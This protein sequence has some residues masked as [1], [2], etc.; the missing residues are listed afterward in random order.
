MHLNRPL[1]WVLIPVL[2]SVG[3]AQAPKPILGFTDASSETQRGLERE[4]DTRISRDNLQ[5]WMRR[6]TAKPHHV[7]SPYG[8]ENAEFALDLFKQWGFEAR[9]EDFDVLFPTPEIRSLTLNAPILYKASLWEPMVKGDAT[10][11]I[12]KDLLPPYNAYSPDGN[13]S[14]EVVYVNYGM[15]DDYKVLASKGIDVKGKI[16]LARY[17]GGWR[18]LKPK[19]AWEHGA[20]GCLI[21][22]DPRDDGF[23]QG[24]VYPAGAFRNDDGVQRGSIADMPIHPG[25]PL[26]PNEPSID[27]VKR[28][29]LQEA[30]TLCKIPTL[31]ISYG[32][33]Q[34]ILKNL[35]GAVV[36]E[37]WRGA[38]PLTYHFGPG[39]A[40]V[41]LKLKF[42]WS[43]VQCRD[44]IAVLKGSERPDQWILRGNHYDGWVFGA[45][46]P[47]SGAVALL[48]EA[49][50]VG[51]LAKL[52]HPPRRTI[53]YCLWDGEEPGLLGSTEWVEKHAE[54]LTEKGVVYINSDSTGRGFVGMSGSHT[55]EAMINGVAKDVRDPETGLNL[56][57]RAKA[58]AIVGGDKEA[59]TKPDIT[60]GALGSGSD[61]TPFLQHIGVASLDLGFGGEGGSGSY[62]STYDS[63]DHFSRF[64]DPDFVYDALLVKFAGRTTL[65]FANADVVPSD[66]ARLVETVGKYFDEVVKLADTIRAETEE[67][68]RQIADGTLKATFDPKETNVVPKPEDPV[69]ALEFGPLKNAVAKLKEA[70]EVLQIDS[71]RLASMSETNRA[72]FENYA[73]QL[74]RS[75]ID[76]AGLPGRTWYRHLIYAPGLYTGYGVKT[77]PGIRES[78]EQ[79]KWEAFGGQASALIKV[80]ERMTKI[81]EQMKTLG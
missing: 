50:I 43:T 46:D 53:V 66:P 72:A 81:L 15:P 54:E 38:L 57:D 11:S 44:V 13:V 61:F 78:I 26:T 42:K 65:R 7:G 60:I 18:G 30:Q 75:M 2:S 76:V 17:G 19:V 1:S 36:P 63:F 34:P 20:T 48:E 52:G 77:L 70:A 59:R 14:G 5:T 31:P 56:Q 24:D 16:V 41:T 80:L 62:H 67:K 71:L 3:S 64:V 39:P 27:G 25:D 74:D 22:S 45:Q 73:I 32:D 28:L 4:L 69:P 29:T 10:S 35:S 33:A 51:E 58:K 8:K 79:R 9:I 23:F 6:M 37:A 40:T 47:I 49:R 21:Y 55:L 68:N 12:R